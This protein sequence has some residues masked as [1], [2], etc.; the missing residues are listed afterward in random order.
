[1]FYVTDI[2]RKEDGNREFRKKMDRW[3]VIG[4]PA[5]VHAIKVADL[6]DNCTSITAHDKDFARV[7]MKE[8]KAL[9]SKLTL[10]PHYLVEHAWSLV[11]KWEQEQLDAALK[12]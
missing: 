2:S 8:K 7:Y 9:L 4:G 6:V 1:M 3:H 12:P 5:A 10:G 11:R